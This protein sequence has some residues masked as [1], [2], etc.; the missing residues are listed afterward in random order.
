MAQLP[1]ASQGVARDRAPQPSLAALDACLQHLRRLAAAQV[2]REDRQRIQAWRSW[3]QVELGTRPGAVY[4]WLKEEGFSPPVVFIARPDGSPTAEVQE[5][6][7]LIRAAWGPINRKYAEGL[8]PC[9]EAFM[10]QYG[11]LLHRVPM[12]AKRL[13]GPYLKRRLMAMRP[14]AMGLDGWSLHDQR[15][16]PD[17]VAELA[18]PAPLAGGGAG[19]VALGAGPGVHLPHPQARGGGAPG[20]TPTDGPVHGLPTVG[21]D[22]AVGGHALAGVLG[23][24]AGLW[25]PPG[26]GGRGRRSGD[27]GPPRARAAEGLVL[28]G[29]E[30]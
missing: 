11:H 19:A 16:L 14:S 29:T 30:P 1:L 18:G 17:P 26:A 27:P 6:D 20:H 3:L 21:R 15:A 5:M 24:P 12:L 2:Q 4:R 9:P 13:S 23:P 28:G 7:D 8:E 25:L 22:P 10:A